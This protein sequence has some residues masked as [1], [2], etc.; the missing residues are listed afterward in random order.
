MEIHQIRYF[1]AASEEQSFTRAAKRC[2]VTQ[3]SLSNAIKRLE[4]ELGSRLFERRSPVQLSSLGRELLPVLAVID[5]MVARARS[6]AAEH[7]DHVTTTVVESQ[8]PGR[9]L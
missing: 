8:S 9:Q 5:Q 3:P 7:R 2:G 4:C 1:L 6:L